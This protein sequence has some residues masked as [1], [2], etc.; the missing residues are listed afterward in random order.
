MLMINVGSQ[1]LGGKVVKVTKNN[2]RI[3][4]S[5]PVCANLGDKI[6]MSRRV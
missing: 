5:K 6:A 3:E 2:A 4:F 1:S